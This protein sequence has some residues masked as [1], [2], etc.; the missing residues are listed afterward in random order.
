MSEPEKTAPTVR[1][2]E[3]ILDKMPVPAPR[4]M[5]DVFA[6]VTK[7]KLLAAPLKETPMPE[8]IEKPAGA[9]R[10]PR[11]TRLDSGAVCIDY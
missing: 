8:K 9:T 2:P 3:T 1:T 11:V 5:E 6:G 7:Q 10:E 4:T